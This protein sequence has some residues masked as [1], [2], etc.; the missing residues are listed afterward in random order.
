VQTEDTIDQAEQEFAGAASGQ[1]WVR[2]R[3][4]VIANEVLTP[5]GIASDAGLR[6]SLLARNLGQ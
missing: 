2:S 5:C 4:G 6:E 3:T 1:R